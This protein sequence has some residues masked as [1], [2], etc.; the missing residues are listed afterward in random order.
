MNKGNSTILWQCQKVNWILRKSFCTSGPQLSCYRVALFPLGGQWS[1]AGHHAWAPRSPPAYSWAEL[2]QLKAQTNV[3]LF[4]LELQLPT[5]P[6]EWALHQ[7]A[8]HITAS[9]D[10]WLA[11]QTS[12]RQRGW[13]QMVKGVP[14]WDQPKEWVWVFLSSSFGSCPSRASLSHITLLHHPEPGTPRHINRA[15]VAWTD[16]SDMWP[17][18]SHRPCVWFNDRSF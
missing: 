5:Q 18:Q 13:E 15:N 4:F 14:E 11:G 10:P 17:G 16:L 7:D 9:A 8:L 12:Y 6:W 1:T 3:V 2:C